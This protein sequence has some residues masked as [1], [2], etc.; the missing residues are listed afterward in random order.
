MVPLD[1]GVNDPEYMSRKI[2]SFQ[3]IDSIRKTIG[4]FFSILLTADQPFTLYKSYTS[5]KLLDLRIEFIRC[6]L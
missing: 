4:S 2:E 3:Q 6:R 1:E 5:Q